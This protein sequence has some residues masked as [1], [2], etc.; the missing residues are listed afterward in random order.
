MDVK[1]ITYFHNEIYRHNPNANEAKKNP[2]QKEYMELKL[3]GRCIGTREIYSKR[4]RRVR[5]L[6]RQQLEIID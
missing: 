3:N 6:R 4:F 2:R 5:V 1:Y